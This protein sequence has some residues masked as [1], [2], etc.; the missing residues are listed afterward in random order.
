[1]PVCKIPPHGAHVPQILER[2][3]G[4]P[5]ECGRSPPSVLYSL[6]DSRRE[7]WATSCGRPMAS[8][9]WLGSRRAGGAGGAGG[10]ADALHIQKQQQ[11]LALDAL[12]AEVDV[13]GQTVS[14]GRRS[15]RCGEFCSAPAISRSRMAATSGHVLVHVV[16][17]F[18]QCS[19]HAADTGDV[20]GTGALA[21]LLRA[22]LDDAHQGEA[23]ADIQR[24]HA[25]GAVELVA[26]HGRAYRCS[27]SLTL[28]CRWPDGL[29]GVGVEGHARFMA[30]GADLRDGQDGADLVI[31]VHGGDQTGVGDGWRPSPAER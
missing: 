4:R 7:P 12:K 26:G 5:S 13:A 9:T 1:M 8:S 23:P 27:C 29:N 10:S 6:R 21:P 11:A 25:L 19:C 18:L 16:A 22:A 14:R 15:G 28:M 3:R 30:D 17:G 2:P 20:L 31:G 24:A